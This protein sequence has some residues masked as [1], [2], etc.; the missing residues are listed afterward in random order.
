MSGR[1]CIGVSGWTYKPWRGVFY[2]DKLPQKSELAWAAGR[3]SS[4]EI[5][6]TFYALQTPA[7]FGR[8]AA[9]T[10]A[11]FVFS[12][13]APR[14]ITHIRRARDVAGPLA[15]FM[16]SG[17][18]R[19]GPKLGP[20]LWQFPPSF[21]YHRDEIE[22]FLAQLP[23]E[24]AAA[25]EMARGHDDWMRQRAWLETVPAQALRHTIEIRH[26]SFATP[27]FIDLLRRYRVALVCADTTAWPCLMD[28]TADFV[29]CRLHGTGARYAEGYDPAAIDAWA[30]RVRAWAQGA[31]P[32]D[33]ER[34]TPASPRV[35]DGRDVFVYFDND[36]K[37]R[38]PIDA[39]S[40]IERLTG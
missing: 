26:A 36:H 30:R 3:L 10:P 29:Y 13:K 37:V 25:L 1:I 39:Q 23:H 22:S 2:P 15:N 4:I 14:Y 21:H 27:E 32:D 5:N 17:I 34:L 40:L 16:A 19:L 18:F 38:A 8:W 35:P 9:E 33:A 11:D 24:P 20:I 31:E 6:G 28:V 7:S 12:V